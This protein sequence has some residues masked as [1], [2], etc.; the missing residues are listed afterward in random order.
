MTVRGVDVAGMCASHHG[1][2]S[3][4]QRVKVPV[5]LPGPDYGDRISIA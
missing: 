1:M 5:G 3:P 2:V 4:S